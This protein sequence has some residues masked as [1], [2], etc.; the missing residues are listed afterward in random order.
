MNSLA[1]MMGLQQPNMGNVRQPK[2]FGAFEQKQQQF[3]ANPFQQ[4]PQFPQLPPQ[5]GAFQ[6]QMH[7][8]I[9]Q[10]DQSQNGPQNP[11]FGYQN[12][13]MKQPVQ[14]H[15]WQQNRQPNRGGYFSGDL[16]TPDMQQP[17]WWGG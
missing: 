9:P 16:G 1:N 6:Q 13:M 14:R 2:Q 7:Q 15:Q 11:Q 8:Q 12:G 10:F 4:P 17:K 5:F 3:G